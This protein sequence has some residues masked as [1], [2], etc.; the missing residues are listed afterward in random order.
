MKAMILIAGVATVGLSIPAYADP[1]KDEGG[2][3]GWR[4]GYYS[5]YDRY[6][7][8]DDRSSSSRATAARSSVSGRRAN[9]KR[10]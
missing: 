2:H 5:Q 8:A 7:Y 9:T 10:R 6:G 3:G 4:G 1:D